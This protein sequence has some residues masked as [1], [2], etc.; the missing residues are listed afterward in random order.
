M[1]VP[2]PTFRAINRQ[3]LKSATGA[4]IA[5]YTLGPRWC[6]IVLDRDSSRVLD[7]R[8]PEGPSRD[9]MAQIAADMS[10]LFVHSHASGWCFVCSFESDYEA[11]VAPRACADTFVMALVLAELGDVTLARRIAPIVAEAAAQ[12]NAAPTRRERC[13]IAGPITDTMA[14]RLKR[15]APW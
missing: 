1:S 7:A 14:Q 9:V 12:V 5:G 10:R 8:W 4:S 11:L 15:G 2:I 3:Q 13:R 6:R